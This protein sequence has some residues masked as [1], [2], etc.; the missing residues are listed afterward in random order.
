M[1]S[2]IIAFDWLDDAAFALS[3][4][5]MRIAYRRLRWTHTHNSVVSDIIIKNVRT[6]TK[7]K[8]ENQIKME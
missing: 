6:K 4:D 5:T 2:K 3:Y 7:D 1:W 8:F